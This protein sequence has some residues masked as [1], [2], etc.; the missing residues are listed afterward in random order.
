VNF[1]PFR[2]RHPEQ[3]TGLIVVL[4]FCSYQVLVPRY[5][6]SMI[7]SI[8]VLYNI[9][10]RRH[11]VPRVSSFPRRYWPTGRG[12]GGPKRE[13]YS[14][15]FSDDA[16]IRPRTHNR[17][18]P[19]GS[20]V[21]LATECTFLLFNFSICIRT[22]IHDWFT[23]MFSSTF[24]SQAFLLSRNSWLLLFVQWLEHHSFALAVSKPRHYRY[25][26]N[27]PRPLSLS[28]SDSSMIEDTSMK[29]ALSLRARGDE[30]ENEKNEGPRMLLS[31][32]LSARPKM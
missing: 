3:E 32:V 9:F 5:F 1:G 25:N 20:D 29:R 16:A 23:A 24:G 18:T 6:C 17:K 4:C 19:A 27:I 13:K 22:A 30:F 10:G 28:S 11:D 7:I 31:G 14:L 12:R 8:R 15:P 2:K 21:V 26:S